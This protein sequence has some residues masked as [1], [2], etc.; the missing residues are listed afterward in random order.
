MKIIKGDGGKGTC[1]EPTLC[2]TRCILYHLYSCHLKKQVCSPSHCISLDKETNTQFKLPKIQ[3]L[4]NCKFRI[5]IHILLHSPFYC[6]WIFS[7]WREAGS[8]YPLTEEGAGHSAGWRTYVNHPED[9]LELC[10]WHSA[11]SHL[12]Q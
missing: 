3:L 2:Q 4:A 12:P 11:S 7:H 10:S 8:F 9:F 1:Q 6:P 5:R